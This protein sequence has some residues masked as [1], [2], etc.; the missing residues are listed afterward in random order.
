MSGSTDM[1]KKNGTLYFSNKTKT[2]DHINLI[3]SG[4]HI[5]VMPHVSWKFVKR[6]KAIVMFLVKEAKIFINI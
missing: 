6:N 5:H 2:V 4:I 1:L 3:P